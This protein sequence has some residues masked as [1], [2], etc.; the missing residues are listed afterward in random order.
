MFA[1]LG[2]ALALDDSGRESEIQSNQEAFY[3]MNEA[4]RAKLESVR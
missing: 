1:V 3:A 2:S 4:L